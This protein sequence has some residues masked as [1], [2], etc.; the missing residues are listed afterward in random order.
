MA[1][2]A[3]R[4]PEN[5]PGAFYTDS[6]CIDCDLC[7][8]TAPDFFDRNADGGYTFIKKQPANDEEKAQIEQ[9]AKDC[10]VEAI[11]ADGQ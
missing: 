3:D 5:A 1:S 4:H 9:A 2:L 10:P 8:Q 6:Q 11:G 7:R